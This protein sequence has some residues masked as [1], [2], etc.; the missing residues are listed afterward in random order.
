MCIHV[1]IT[2]S[3]SSLVYKPATTNPY[4]SLLVG[5]LLWKKTTKPTNRYQTGHEMKSK[6]Q[7]STV[8]VVNGAILLLISDVMTGTINVGQILNLAYVHGVS[9]IHSQLTINCFQ[10]FR[11]PVP[12]FSCSI[13]STNMNQHHFSQV[14]DLDTEGRTSYMSL[15]TRKQGYDV[16]TSTQ[17]KY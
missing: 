9:N 1:V 17:C 16:M 13:D 4:C 10:L 5:K 12:L 7:V 14:Q 8:K 3:V 6:V 11:G 15:W 2:V